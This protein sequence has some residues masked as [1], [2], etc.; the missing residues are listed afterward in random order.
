MCHDESLMITNITS[1]PARRKVQNIFEDQIPDSARS[2]LKKKNYEDRR[3]VLLQCAIDGKIVGG[4]LALHPSSQFDGALRRVD[5]T[6]K[7]DF[8]ESLATRAILEV[9]VL[10]EYQNMGIG[11]KL[12]AQAEKAFTEA[13]ATIS[14]L[15]VDSR[16]SES[17]HRFWK[18]MGYT[19]GDP[20]EKGE[21][22][23][24][25]PPEASILARIPNARAGTA[26]YRYLES[27]RKLQ[28]VEAPSTQS[29][30]EATTVKSSEPP[31]SWLRRWLPLI[32][33]LISA[34]VVTG[35]MLWIP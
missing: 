13:G 31:R 1:A 11:Q 20:N 34:V 10:S 32:S 17:T 29:Q 15:Y 23:T 8:P 35:I 16:S 26:Y 14:L 27:P 28:V 12:V 18:K 24:G 30:P 19:P 7:D 4:L 5:M 3:S 25:L 21:C 2:L 6:V 22:C 9:A 33:L